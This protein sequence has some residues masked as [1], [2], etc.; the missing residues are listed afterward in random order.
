L[1]IYSDQSFRSLPVTT[2][3]LPPWFSFD[4]IDQR[5]RIAFSAYLLNGYVIF[6]FIFAI[7]E[8][9]EIISNF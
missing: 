1:L 8:T 7:F 6:H 5:E 2:T 9:Y 3:A 4:E